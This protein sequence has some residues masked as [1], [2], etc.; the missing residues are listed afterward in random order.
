[1]DGSDVGPYDLCWFHPSTTTISGMT[2]SGKTEFMKKIIK[3]RDQLFETKIEKIIW[4]YGEEIPSLIAELKNEVEFHHGISQDIVSKENLN[5]KATILVVDDLQSDI[6]PKLLGAL[7]TKYR[8]F[9]K[10]LSF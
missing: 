5:G 7:F 3:Y 9:E 10:T 6:D 1:M 2:G 4:C 8:Y